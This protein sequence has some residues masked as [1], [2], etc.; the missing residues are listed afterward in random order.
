VIGRQAPQDGMRF[1]M[2]PG[3]LRKPT[4]I[5]SDAPTKKKK[6]FFKK[7]KQKTFALC[8]KP[9]VQMGKSGAALDR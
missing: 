6:Y 9:P 1:S 4:G 7:K 2:P 3:R 5:T 8:A